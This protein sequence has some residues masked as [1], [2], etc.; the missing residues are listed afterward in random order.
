MARPAP[1]QG[2]CA[3]TCT[4]ALSAARACR[5]GAAQGTALPLRGSLAGSLWLAGRPC[6]AQWRG[7]GAP[8]SATLGTS[9]SRR[10]QRGGMGFSS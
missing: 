10:P 3:L 5:R 9:L 1:Q 8:G 6:G 4:A 2:R 7:R